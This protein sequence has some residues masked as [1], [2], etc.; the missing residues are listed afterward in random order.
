M[1]YSCGPLHIDVQKQDNQLE[2]IY[3]SPV[4]IQD[5]DLNTFRERWTLEKGGGRGSGR[6]VLVARDDDDDD[7]SAGG[8]FYVTP[9]GIS[10]RLKE[11]IIICSLM[12]LNQ[13]SHE[14][15]RNLYDAVVDAL[16]NDVIAGE[17]KLQ[18]CHYVHF[19]TNALGKGMNRFIPQLWVKKW[20]Y[21]SRMAL[22]FNNTW[23][24]ICH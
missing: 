24:L 1:T 6:F 15:W 5:V 22:A 20:Y 18:S 12:Y 3:N 23:R 13:R 9:E 14:K 21:S 17:F 11:D 19:W 10:I 8:I 7:T 2:P 4:P 16:D